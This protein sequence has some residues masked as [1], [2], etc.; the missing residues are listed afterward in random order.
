MYG[1]IELVPPELE[2]PD[3]VL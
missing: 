2:W 3:T 1:Y